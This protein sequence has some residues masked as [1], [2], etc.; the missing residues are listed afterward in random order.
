LL[1]RSPPADLADLDGHLVLSE[2][3]ADSYGRATRSQDAPILISVHTSPGR[4][5]LEVT[6]HRDF[7][8]TA[9]AAEELLFSMR[10]LRF[11]NQGD[12]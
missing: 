2:I 12:R 9:E 10:G 3:V 5:R 8:L 1:R 4:L 6:D 11:V 7:D